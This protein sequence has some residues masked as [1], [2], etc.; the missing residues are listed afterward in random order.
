MQEVEN[1]VARMMKVNTRTLIAGLLG[2][3]GLLADPPKKEGTL[4]QLVS[5]E[6]GW[7]LADGS[8]AAVKSWLRDLADM[9]RRHLGDV[10]PPDRT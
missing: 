5:W 2:I 6:V 3:E 8:D 7:V 1:D 10:V 9:L 4:A